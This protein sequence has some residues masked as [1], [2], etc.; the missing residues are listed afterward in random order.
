M[1]GQA[2]NQYSI[3]RLQFRNKYAT[4]AILKVEK[5][6]QYSLQFQKNRDLSKHNRKKILNGKKMR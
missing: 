1:L 3:M 5:S 4:N 6:P 2:K